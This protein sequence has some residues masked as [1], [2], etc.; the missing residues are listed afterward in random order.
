MGR[1]PTS[2]VHW[3]TSLEI[4][5]PIASSPRPRTANRMAM[6]NSGDPDTSS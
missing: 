1:L 5:A 2:R 4:R 6:M 3:S